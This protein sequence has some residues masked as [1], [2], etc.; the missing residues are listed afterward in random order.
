MKKFIDNF[1]KDNLIVMTCVV[2]AIPCLLILGN[3]TAA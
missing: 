3:Y 1:G 2:V